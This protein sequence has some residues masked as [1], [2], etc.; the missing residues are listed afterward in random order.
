MDELLTPLLTLILLRLLLA[1]LALPCDTV[2][3]YFFVVL[4]I[5]KSMPLP[6]M[7]LLGEHPP[8][9]DPGGVGSASINAA[10]FDLKKSIILLQSGSPYVVILVLSLSF[11]F[12]L[13]LP[14]PCISLC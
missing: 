12:S 11:G 9:S 3:S 14:P 7:D 8:S 4:L 1:L 5:E 2:S 6:L 13:C 10:G